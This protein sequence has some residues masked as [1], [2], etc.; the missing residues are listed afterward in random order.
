MGVF[1]LGFCFAL[2]LCFNVCYGMVGKELEKEL[3]L[4][5]EN[6]FPSVAFVFLSLGAHSKTSTRCVT[7]TWRGVRFAVGKGNL[8]NY[9]LQDKFL[10]ITTWPRNHRY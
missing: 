10:A 9:C 8:L 2:F 7:G 3:H 1:R 4:E 5:Q 6:I